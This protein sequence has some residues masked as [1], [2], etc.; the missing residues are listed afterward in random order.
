MSIYSTN[1]NNKDNNKDNIIIINDY[2]TKSV[3]NI[4]KNSKRCSDN[5]TTNSGLNKFTK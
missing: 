4:F 5:S 2:Q 1:T 3:S